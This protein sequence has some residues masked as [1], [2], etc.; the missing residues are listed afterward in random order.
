MGGFVVSELRARYLHALIRSLTAHV[1]PGVLYALARGGEVTRAR[2]L[3]DL[4]PAAARTLSFV[5][6]AVALMRS[7]ERDEAEVL[8]DEALR[9]LDVPPMTNATLTDRLS[10]ATQNVEPDSE[11]GSTLRLAF[12][13]LTTQDHAIT[14]GR[15]SPEHDD[16]AIAEAARDLLSR[17]PQ[18]FDDVA[19]ESLPPSDASPRELADAVIDV[20]QRYLWRL[21]FEWL[22][23]FAAMLARTDDPK[24]VE[25]GLLVSLRWR[26]DVYGEHAA[27][28]GALAEAC[29]RVGAAEGLVLILDEI[30]RERDNTTRANALTRVA[31]PLA[32]LG[33]ASLLERFERL[34][35]GLD[36]AFVS[37][38]RVLARLVR[39]LAEAQRVSEAVT[40]AES[41]V[42]RL[43]SAPDDPE[44]R[45]ALGMAVADALVATGRRHDAISVYRSLVAVTE[46]FVEMSAEGAVPS[47][48]MGDRAMAL[49]DV[50]GGLASAGDLDGAW[51]AADLAFDAAAHTLGRRQWCI[52][53]G[54]RI[55][56]RFAAVGDADLTRA[57]VHAAGQA[58]GDPSAP[59]IAAATSASLGARVAPALHAHGALEIAAGLLNDAMV[60]LRNAEAF[61]S[62]FIDVDDLRADLA[63]AV[64]QTR[65][66]WRPTANAI[67]SASRRR[68]KPTFAAHR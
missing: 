43:E 23:A 33:D 68:I 66:I 3:A 60:V 38:V 42:A 17:L 4:L 7:G 61:G 48:G 53:V 15:H 28:W 32:A 30:E 26:E 62:D 54:G 18:E 50:A 58:S 46:D 56:E 49:A 22:H 59:D 19:V 44:I 36:A 9:A 27:V 16:V 20:A 45:V 10:T 29:E 37:P 21:D 12:R 67:A 57:T 52:A 5:L 55:A 63:I 47:R 25:R 24:L 6:I 14:E 65:S 31:A 39:E 11:L 34:A 13:V 8:V 40:H 2:A 41:L 35:L 64:A 51:E 1:P